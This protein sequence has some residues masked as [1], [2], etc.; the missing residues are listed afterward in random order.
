MAAMITLFRCRLHTLF[1]FQLLNQDMTKENP[2]LMSICPADVCRLSYFRLYY[3]SI[4]L[5]NLVNI[6]LSES[7]QLKKVWHPNFPSWPDKIVKNVLENGSGTKAYLRKIR[8]ISLEKV[9]AALTKV[10]PLPEDAIK[11]V[12]EKFVEIC[13]EDPNNDFLWRVEEEIPESGDSVNHGFLREKYSHLAGMFNC[14]KHNRE[15]V[16]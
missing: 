3:L 13:D 14:L 6:A 5:E 1:V 9:I 7:E 8:N 12:I 16:K 2:L 10:L 4:K 11:I 15:K